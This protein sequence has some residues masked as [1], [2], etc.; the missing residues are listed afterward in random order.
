IGGSGIGYVWQKDQIDRLGKQLLQRERRLTQLEEQNEKLRKQLGTM[1]SPRF[2]EMRIKEL[3]LGLVPPQ[4]TQVWR[5]TEP[6]R[7]TS[8]KPEPQRQ[9]A[10]QND[11]A[12]LVQ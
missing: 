6:A 4:Q 8:P 12:A 9:F 3:N 2:L 7:E 1:R 10:A 5:L 11:R